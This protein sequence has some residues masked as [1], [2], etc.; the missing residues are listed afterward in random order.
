MSG[1][2]NLNSSNGGNNAEFNR[3]STIGS[4]ANKLDQ[5]GGKSNLFAQTGNIRPITR[6]VKL[7]S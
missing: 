1:N 4:Q 2:D 3:S 7:R 6:D 5:G